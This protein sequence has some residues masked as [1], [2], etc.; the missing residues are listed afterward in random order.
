MGKGSANGEGEGRGRNGGAEGRGDDRVRRH[1]VASNP[2][3]AL[4]AARET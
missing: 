3:T 4:L 2:L 1:K